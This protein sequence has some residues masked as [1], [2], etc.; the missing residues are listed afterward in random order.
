MRRIAMSWIRRFGNV[1]RQDRL[2]REIDE[3]LA[4]HIEGAIEQGNSADEARQALGSA[5]QYREQSRDIQLLPWLDSLVSDVVFGWRQLNRRR[6]ANA[7]A[8][9]SLGLAIGATT[10]AFRLVDAVLLRRLLVAEPDRLY[11]LAF[12]NFKNADGQADYNEYFDYPAY[13]KYRE[14]VG[15]RAELMVI[16]ISYQQD[17]TFGPGAEPVKLFQQFYSGNVFG[18]FSLRPAIGRLLAPS[19]DLVPGGHPVAVI[20]YDLWTRRFGRDPQVLG[21][22]GWRR[23]RRRRER[24]RFPIT[25]RRRSASSWGYNWP[26]R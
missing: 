12:T 17:A 26:E 14:T 4:S 15:D 7:A 19:D 5:L 8:I 20:S 25:G 22:R 6:V 16:G 18:V 21:M 1:F 9:L 10:A 3:E 11:Y 13:R 2:N 24:L 23:W